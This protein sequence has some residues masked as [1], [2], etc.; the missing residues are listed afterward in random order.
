[1]YKPKMTIKEPEISCCCLPC[2][3]IKTWY[4]YSTNPVDMSVWARMK[5]FSYWLL[6][7]ISFIPFYGI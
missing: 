3:K 5:T 1:M 4:N 6:A 2:H 7:S